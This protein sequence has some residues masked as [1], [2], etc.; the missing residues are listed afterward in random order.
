MRADEVSLP[1]AQNEKLP[2]VPEASDKI[3]HPP[4]PITVEELDKLLATERITVVNGIKLIGE[5]P[6]DPSDARL[7]FCCRCERL[8]LTVD[9]DRN[10]YANLIAESSAPGS[11]IEIGWEER[12][13]EADK[14]VVY[15]T[16]MEYVRIFDNGRKV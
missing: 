9:V 1:F 5:V 16:Y 4:T 10:K 15:V 3:Q 7:R 13:K 8:D 14:L 2:D 12:V 6:T 11:R